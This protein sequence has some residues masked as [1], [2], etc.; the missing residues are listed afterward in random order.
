M[1]QEFLDQLARWHDED[2]YQKIIDAIEGLPQGELTPALT[3]DLARAYNNL[4]PAGEEGRP[5]LEKALSLLLPLEGELGGDHCWNYR[6]G[7]AYYYLDREEEALPYFQRALEARP[8]DEDTQE[9]IREC[10]KYIAAKSCHPE[11]YGEEDWKAVDA[12]IERYF[13]K[14]ENVFHE[15][16]SPDIHVDIYIIPPT[17]ERNYYTL[18]THGMGAH[19]MNVPAGLADRKLERAEL[20]VCLPPDWKI[21]QE[22]E[23]WYWPI[24]W[25]KIMARLPINEDSWLGWGHTVANPDDAPFAGNTGLCGVMLMAPGAFGEE[26]FCCP[27][28]DGDEVNF[29]QLLPLYFEEM[30]FKLAHDA[31]ALLERFPEQLLEVVDINRPNVCGD[32]PAKAFLIPGEAL[33]KLYDGDGPQGCVATDRILVDGQRVGYCW[34]VEPEESDKDW[35]SGWRFVAGDEDQDYM[36]DPRNSGVYALNTICNYDPD[37]L[38]LLDSETGTAWS[39]GEDGVFRPELYQSGEE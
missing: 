17:A 32:R 12:H 18:A 28:P 15:L 30:Q 6:V 21:G 38:S 37:I 8:D 1:N 31:G 23:E 39:R 3:S 25:L 35:D 5:M 16:V 20:I 33:K 26:S 13:G 24:R 22:E 14:S 2:E 4:A 9:M 34:R 11:L 27:L 10:E 7:Y 36:D 19:R 29:Y